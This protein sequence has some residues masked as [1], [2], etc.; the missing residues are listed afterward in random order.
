[1]PRLDGIEVA[2][3]L[4]RSDD[5]PIRVP[6]PRGAVACVEGRASSIDDY[7]VEAKRP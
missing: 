4:R 3:T 6:T 5:R 1:L 7:L 2:K